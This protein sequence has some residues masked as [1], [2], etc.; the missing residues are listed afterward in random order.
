MRKLIEG[1]ITA[2]IV[3][4]LIASVVG[5]LLD[6]PIFLSYA[7]SESMTPTINKGDLFFINPLSKGGEVGD[8][9]VFHRRDGWT[10]HRIFAVT[11]AGYITKGDNNVATDQQD[12]GYP[13]VKKADVIGKVVTLFGHPLVIRGGGS[14]IESV[15]GRLT[16]VYAIALILLL[17]VFITFSGSGGG[18]KR[19]KKGK[20]RRYLKI[21][22]STVYALIAVSIVAGFLFITVASWG[23]LAFTYSSTL[24][25]GQREGWYLPGSTFEKNLSVENNALYPFHYFV[26]P[27]GDRI[28]LL[29]E[30]EFT[31]GGRDSHVLGVKVSVPEDTRIYREEIYVRTYPAILPETVIG[32][33]YA[34]NPYLPLLA[35]A[36]ELTAVLLAFSY[37]AEISRED[38]LRIRIGR[39]S[40]LS[41]LAGD[42]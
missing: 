16:N 3:V 32:F 8:I 39:R 11:E 35:Y 6:R 38:I 24:A 26:E 37:L 36:L 21:R 12:G 2:V 28:K 19:H 22:A 42:D 10:V 25:G 30:N 34:L 31:V 15:R 13:I 1:I 40:L 33:L 20:G 9:I 4:I 7:Y 23:T 29:E 5:F 14:F 27:K 41:K 17:G 18:K